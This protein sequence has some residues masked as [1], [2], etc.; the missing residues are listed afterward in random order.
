MVISLVLGSGIERNFHQSLAMSSGTWSIFMLRPLALMLVV[1]I[2]VA[3]LLAPTK[4]AS[5]R[6]S[7]RR[8]SG[9]T[10]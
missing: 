5:R 10:A 2:V 9:G 6:L 7:L 8:R 3:L 1:C 4:A